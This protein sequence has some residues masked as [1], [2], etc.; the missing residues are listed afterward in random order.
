MRAKTTLQGVLKGGQS[1]AE[2][3]ARTNDR[4]CEGNLE[5][6]FV[7]AW[8]GICDLVTGEVEYVNAGHNPPVI[9]RADG[10]VEWVRPRSG[11]VMA[12]MPGAK[13]RSHVVTLKPGD[14]LVLYTDGVT[15]AQNIDSELYG[16][17]RLEA[18][19]QGIHISL[20]AHQ[21]C[22]RIWDSL[23]DFVGEAE[24]ADDI[25]MLAFRLKRFASANT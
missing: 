19:T 10:S 25:T 24:Q 14:G 3:V 2:A 18:A 20:D 21:Y 16:E 15:E 22:D 4:L 12:A 5:D 6:M 23:E 7:T 8:V 9:R 1:L 11:L 17:P 13:Y